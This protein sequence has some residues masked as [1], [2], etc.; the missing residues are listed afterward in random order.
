LDCFPIF[1][2]M[3]GTEF[4]QKTCPHCGS[5]LGGYPAMT[6]RST[7]TGSN[8]RNGSRS[9][10]GDQALEHCSLGS[11][12]PHR[13]L[14]ILPE[15]A[16]VPASSLN[17]SLVYLPSITCHLNRNPSLIDSRP[18]RNHLLPFLLGDHS[19]QSV[20]AAPSVASHRVPRK[21]IITRG[22]TS[23]PIPTLF[24]TELFQNIAPRS[25]RGCLRMDPGANGNLEIAI[26][27]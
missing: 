24:W 27:I 18:L 22:P 5:N 23:R 2:T 21:P 1:I 3:F 14:P 26:S 20:G 9:I 8:F 12:R 11:A 10:P 7:Q 13:R 6:S 15:N 19:L 16:A 17:H 4:R 25:K